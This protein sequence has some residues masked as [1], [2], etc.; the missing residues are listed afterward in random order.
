MNE[1]V[2]TLMKAVTDLK[3]LMAD[4]TVKSGKLETDAIKRDELEKMKADFLAQLETV[5][6][7][8]AKSKMVKP[9]AEKKSAAGLI[10][11]MKAVKAKDIEYIKAQSEDANADGLY[12]VPQGLANYILGVLTD[13]TTVVP[14]CT[15]F[16]HGPTDGFVKKIP[17]WLTGVTA[18]WYA[19]EGVRTLSAFTFSQVTSTL[20]MMGALISDS[21][22]LSADNIVALDNAMAVEVKRAIDYELERVILAGDVTGAGDAFNGVL[23]ASGTKSVSQAAATLGYKDL[24]GIWNNPDVKIAYKRGAEWYMNQTVFGKVLEIVDAFGRPIWQA[25]PLTDGVKMSILGAPL[26]LSDAIPNTFGADSDKSAIIYGNFKNVIVGNKAGDTGIKV[27][28]S[29]TAVIASTA[30]AGTVTENAWQQYLNMWRFNTRRSVV[31]AVP[32][33]FSVMTSVVVA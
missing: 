33:A 6:K 1:Q 31:V 22:E 13:D 29:N 28:Y 23:Y 18:G 8:L 9:D 26:N 30:P 2:E 25:T 21:E 7:D 3:G 32:A 12:T 15:A 11:F 14:K 17:T 10:R 20:K 4:L 16:P 24:I 27:E 5:Q 19:E